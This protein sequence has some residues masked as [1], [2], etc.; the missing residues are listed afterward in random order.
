MFD[1]PT[2]P[3]ARL[4]LRPFRTEDA[5]EVTAL[6][7]DPAIAATT[8]RLPHPYSFED[9]SRFIEDIRKGWDAGTSAVFAVVQCDGDVLTGTVGLE[10]TP[11]H[12]HAELG[13]W[14]GKP[15]WNRGFATEAAAALVGFGFDALDLNRIH[16]HHMTRNPASGR[17]LERIGMAREG[18]LRAHIMKADAFED[19]AW[20]GILRDEHVPPD[21]TGT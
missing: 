13:Y 8:M 7:G 3:T 10:I 1:Q 20:Y 12:R 17:V 4:R 5:P 11:A 14:V 21:P 2:I 6:A 16:A 18:V 19:I 15:Y 9:A